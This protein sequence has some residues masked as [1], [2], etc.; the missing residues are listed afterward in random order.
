MASGPVFQTMVRLELPVWVSRSVVKDDSLV[1]IVSQLLCEGKKEGVGGGEEKMVFHSLL[2]TLEYQGFILALTI[3]TFH[4]SLFSNITPQVSI[5]E[6][7]P[8][9]E[10]RDVSHVL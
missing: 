6:E 9:S 1:E 2:S 8:I 3:Y 10:N 7:A 4:S 5:T